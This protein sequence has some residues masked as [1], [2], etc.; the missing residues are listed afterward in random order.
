MSTYD[1][2]QIDISPNSRFEWQYLESIGNIWPIQI[3]CDNFRRN[4]NMSEKIFFQIKPPMNYKLTYTT[5]TISS[6]HV[7][8]SMTSKS[9]TNKITKISLVLSELHSNHSEYETH[10]LKICW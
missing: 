4:W 2:I 5:I 9:S 6:I 8:T 1:E 3:I 10:V 7:H